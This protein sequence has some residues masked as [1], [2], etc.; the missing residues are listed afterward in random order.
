M[1]SRD[2]AGP[3]IHDSCAFQLPT[4]PTRSFVHGTQVDIN[5][6]SPS[7]VCGLMDSCKKAGG[8]ASILYANLPSIYG[9]EAE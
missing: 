4:T 5:L 7:F 1:K 9:P 2:I 6:W 8:K 3:M